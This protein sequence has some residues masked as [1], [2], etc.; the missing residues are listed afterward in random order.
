MTWM[1]LFPWFTT[2]FS[3]EGT[4]AVWCFSCT[5]FRSLSVSC[6]ALLSQPLILS[7][8]CLYFR[9]FRLL[10][11]REILNFLNSKLRATSYYWI[12]LQELGSDVNLYAL[13]FGESV[14]N[15]AVSSFRVV[16]L[17]FLI[18]GWKISLTDQVFLFL[19]LLLADGHIS[20]QVCQL[21]QKFLRK[22]DNQM[23][24]YSNK[25]TN[26]GAGQCP[27]WE[28]TQLDRISL[29]SSL[30]FSK[31]LSVQCLQVCF[32]CLYTSCLVWIFL[33]KW[34]GARVWEF[35]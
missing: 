35:C 10:F 22:T 34:H 28:V 7:L 9:Y 13:V 30:G 2:S 32:L 23:V 4:L 3:I 14:L 31:P 16:I 20:V 17:R 18:L 12:V 26:W 27:W 8:S 11:F 15:D 29:W 19:M 25:A 5:D 33:L 6:L 21:I 1:V 24:R